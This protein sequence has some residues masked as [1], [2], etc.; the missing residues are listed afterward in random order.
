MVDPETR[1]G[2]G[3]ILELDREARRLTLKRGPSLEDV[4]LPEALI[5]GSPYR[6]KDQEDA[7]VRLG[8]S[9]LAGDQQLPG[10]RVRAP[11]RAVRPADPDHG[12]RRDE[13]ARALA[14]RPP[15]RHPGAA[16]L[17]QDVDV[18]AADRAPARERQDGRRRLDEPQGDP[19]PARR[20]RRG[21]GRARD[22]LRRPQEGE[23]RQPGVV[24]RQEPIAD[25]EHAGR[26]PRRRPRGRHGVALRPR[27]PAGRLPLHRRGRPGVARRRARDGDGGAEPRARRR[28]AAARPGDPGDAPRRERRLGA[29][30]PA[31]RR[32]DGAA[33][34][35]PL[36]RAHVSAAPG[37]LRL[38]LGGV[39]RRPARAGRRGARTDDAARHRA[40]LRRRRARRRAGRSRP[41]RS[42]SCAASSRS[43][44]PRA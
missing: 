39:L 25:V 33:R 18:R 15:P 24:L 4:P 36:P 37:R 42:T 5:P 32:G 11:A 7:L 28:P 3:E 40:S 6:T 29:A 19:Q 8:R 14:R 9:L 23:R 31:R 34:P 35:R 1:E 44:A 21:G 43:C 38:H 27:E 41:R 12:A 13:G 16:R 17:G 2:A 30:A 10:A 22:R 26:D 20:G